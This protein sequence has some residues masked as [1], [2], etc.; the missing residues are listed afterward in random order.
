MEDYE[1]MEG[2]APRSILLEENIV[3]KRDLNLEGDFIHDSVQIKN[4]SLLFNDAR[5][6]TTKSKVVTEDNPIFKTVDY[7]SNKINNSDLTLDPPKITIKENND[8]ILLLNKKLKSINIDDLANFLSGSKLSDI[9]LKM[10]QR[11]NNLENGSKDTKTTETTE[12]TE[13]AK[14]SS[15]I[16][17]ELLKKELKTCQDT[18]IELETRVKEL[19]NPE[20]IVRATE[21]FTSKINFGI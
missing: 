4:G 10:D 16:E 7:L 1:V 11:V 2:D 3:M 6:L 14:L 18:I 20:K 12:T 5:S 13:T 8:E 21:V 17:V 9:I 15:I 19:E